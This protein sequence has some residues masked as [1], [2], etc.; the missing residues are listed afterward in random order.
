[1]Y[2]MYSKSVVPLKMCNE[3]RT[4]CR[5]VCSYLSLLHFLSVFYS[6]CADYANGHLD[7]CDRNERGGSSGRQLFH[8][9]AV[10]LFAFVETHTEKLTHNLI[11]YHV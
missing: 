8:D 11:I 7:V 5:N 2:R 4:S 3:M 9:I 6:L 10:G 1:M